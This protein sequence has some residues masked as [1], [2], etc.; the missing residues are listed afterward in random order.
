MNP[1]SSSLPHVWK[2]SFQG[3][4]TGGNI[5]TRMNFITDEQVWLRLTFFRVLDISKC[6]VSQQVLTPRMTQI[7]VFFSKLSTNTQY[8]TVTTTY[9]VLPSNQKQSPSKTMSTMKY[10]TQINK[11]YRA[12]YGARLQFFAAIKLHIPAQFL[13]PLCAVGR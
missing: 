5:C 12:S 9:F 13:S 3:H 8:L 4:V 1:G 10:E 6:R 11:Q 7:K 2:D